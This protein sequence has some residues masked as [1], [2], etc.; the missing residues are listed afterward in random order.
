MQLS[1]SF[2]ALS[3]LFLCAAVLNNTPVAASPGPGPTDAALPPVP[4]SIVAEYLAP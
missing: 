2:V 1:I 3:V 4:D